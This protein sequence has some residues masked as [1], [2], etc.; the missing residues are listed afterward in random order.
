MDRHKA[1]KH[2]VECKEEQD[3]CRR[4]HSRSFK[5][6]LNRYKTEVEKRD[7]SRKFIS[8]HVDD[9]LSSLACADPGAI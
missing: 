6:C 1:K 4:D 9:G 3:A 2:P 7:M 5:R 8:T